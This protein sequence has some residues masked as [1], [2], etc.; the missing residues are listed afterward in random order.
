M[1]QRLKLPFPPSLNN[2]FVNAKGGGRIPSQRYKAWTTE[3]LWSLKAQHAMKMA[4]D[5]SIH[6]GIVA[7]DKRSRDCDNLAK[8]VL[9][10]LVK[11][12]VIAD[13]SNRHVRSVSIEW[14]ASGDPCTVIVSQ[15]ME[16]A[17]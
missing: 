5:L 3:A 16:E 4:G 17:A 14:L 8:P 9:D 15:Y 11:A 12:G 7:P 1:R 13:D 2:C 10:L 6:I